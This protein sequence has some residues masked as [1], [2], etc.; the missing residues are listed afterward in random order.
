MSCHIISTKLK[1]LVT[2]EKSAD[3]LMRQSIEKYKNG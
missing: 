2:Q 3:S 1:V